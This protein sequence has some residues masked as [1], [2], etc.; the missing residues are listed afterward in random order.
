MWLDALLNDKNI[1]SYFALWLRLYEMHVFVFQ[2]LNSSPSRFSPYQFHSD[3]K[4]KHL[5]RLLESFFF[6][7]LLQFLYFLLVIFLTTQ[8]S[9]GNQLNT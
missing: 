2:G 7:L 4:T 9:R 8:R 5:E 6:S 1:V 3:T